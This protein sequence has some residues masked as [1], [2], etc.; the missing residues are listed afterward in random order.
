MSVCSLLWGGFIS[1]TLRCTGWYRFFLWEQFPIGFLWD[2][3]RFLCKF[4]GTELLH[5]EGTWENSIPYMWMLCLGVLVSEHQLFPPMFWAS[6]EL[7]LVGPNFLSSWLHRKSSSSFPTVHR[8][9]VLSLYL[10]TN[11]KTAAPQVH[12]SLGYKSCPPP[13]AIR[14]LLTAMDSFQFLTSEI[15]PF[16]LLRLKI[17]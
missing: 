7:G 6:W 14:F 8:D 17:Y 11:T 10:H 2:Y 13:P 3:V 9:C 16:L 12:F 1:W 15:S 4:L 5:C